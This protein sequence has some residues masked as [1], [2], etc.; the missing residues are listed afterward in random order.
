MVVVALGVRE[1]APPDQF[2]PSDF[3]WRLDILE[4]IF[5]PPSIIKRT[6]NVRTL[7]VSTNYLMI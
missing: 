6:H 2:D 3:A 4:A 7:A 1:R 5:L